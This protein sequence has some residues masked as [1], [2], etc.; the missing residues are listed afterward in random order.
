[1]PGMGVTYHLCQLAQEVYK[2]RDDIV[3]VHDGT[4]QEPGLLEK[5][6]AMKVGSST[7]PGNPWS[8]SSSRRRQKATTTSCSTAR[9]SE[10]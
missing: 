9:A 4:E 5:L 3:V 10:A 8:S 6:R 1:M 2:L 7:I